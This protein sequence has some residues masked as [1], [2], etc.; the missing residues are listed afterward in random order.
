MGSSV[1][2]ASAVNTLEEH[3]AADS[4]LNIRKAMVTDDDEG[5]RI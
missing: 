1:P 5:K 4:F 3:V 2:A